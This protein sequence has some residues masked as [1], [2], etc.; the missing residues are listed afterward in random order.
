MTLSFSSDSYRV[1][2]RLLF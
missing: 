1:A 2:Q